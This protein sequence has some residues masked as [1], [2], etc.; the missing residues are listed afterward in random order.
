M[1]VLLSS[2]GRR[3]YLVKYFK[4]ALGPDGQ[5][6]GVDSSPYA[7]GFVYCDN[8]CILPEV[9]NPGYCDKLMA[10]CKKNHIDIVIPLIDPELDVLA[11]RR[12]DFIRNNIMAV[13]S[14]LA[15][16]EMTFDKYHTWQWAEQHGIAMPRTVLTIEE[17][18]DHIR[19]GKMHW[20]LVVKPRKGSASSSISYCNDEVQLR[21]AFDGCP[22]PLIQQF[23]D[24]PEYGYD[25]FSDEKFRPVSVYCKKK[26]AMRAGETDK[27]IST[28]NPTLI[29]FGKKLLGAMQLFGPADVDVI[30]SPDG[31]QL[32]EIN[33]RFGGGYPCAH[34]AGANFCKKLLD[35]RAGKSVAAD[36]DSCPEGVYMLKQDEIIRP[37]W[38]DL[39][40]A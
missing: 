15:T 4:E 20:P 39:P 17:A 7:P 23:V 35:I 13:V 3:G 2:V 21:G 30:L 6:W 29:E 25:L 27:A 24:G 1:R 18:L 26:L 32:L 33:P 12:E 40:G 38:K 11:R 10:L 28:N 36:M 22:E 16:I 8:R 14:P 34:L 19:A 31:P 9:A 5:V 37:D